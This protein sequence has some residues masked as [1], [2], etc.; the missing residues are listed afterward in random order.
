MEEENKQSKPSIPESKRLEIIMLKQDGFSSQE[1]SQRLG[2]SVASCSRIYKHYLE[3]GEVSYSTGGGRPKKISEKAEEMLI[4]YASQNPDLSVDQLLEN[5]QVEASKT[6]GWRALK[7]NG[8][9]YRTVDI[10]WKISPKDQ[11]RRLQWAKEYKFSR[12]FLE[13][14]RF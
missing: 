10:K 6:I 3:T 12:R 4:E 13:K 9:Q 14:G 1:V 11:E 5:T 2:V 7:D 8:F